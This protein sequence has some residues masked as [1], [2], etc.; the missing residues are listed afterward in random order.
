M[1]NV[2]NHI[3]QIDDLKKYYLQ[4]FLNLT[5]LLKERS[6]YSVDDII[7]KI[8]IYIQRNYQKD[9]TQEYISYLF[10][11]NRSYLSTLFKAKTGE[12]FI[13][14]LNNVR[15]NKAK[16]LLEKSDRKMYQIA[17]AVGY[18][19][20]KYFFRIF[21]KKTGMTPEQYRIQKG[22]TL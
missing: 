14:Y 1:Q 4:F 22:S 9:L 11:M 20:V 5:S 16:E 3:Y 17:K 8:K 6:V 7:E 21:K 18:D 12:K 15:I 10:Y 13:D 19:N 2:V